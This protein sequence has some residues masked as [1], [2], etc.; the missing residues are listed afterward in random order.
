MVDSG[1]D[2]LI[3]EINLRPGKTRSLPED[4][5]RRLEERVKASEQRWSVRSSLFKNLFGYKKTRYRGLAKNHAR[6][7]FLFASA[8]VLIAAESGIQ[9]RS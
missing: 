7:L 1:N 8:N 5:V 3:Y 2:N 4:G 6:L 9:C